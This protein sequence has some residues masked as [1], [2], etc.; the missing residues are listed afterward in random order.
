MPR[1]AGANEVISSQKSIRSLSGSSPPVSPSP[2]SKKYI[3]SCLTG[4]QIASINVSG[5]IG[6]GLPVRAKLDHNLTIV[7]SRRSAPV[8]GATSGIRH[9]LNR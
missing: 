4:F 6:F 9:V 1:A 2:M 7:C 5:I 8:P 3:L